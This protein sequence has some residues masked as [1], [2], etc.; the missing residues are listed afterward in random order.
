LIESKTGGSAPDTRD[1]DDTDMSDTLTDETTTEYDERTTI[2]DC[3]DRGEI[4]EVHND[5]DQDVYEIE[6]DDGE[7]DEL[8]ATEL[9]L[10]LAD[11]TIEVV[12]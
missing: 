3:G 1:H 10:G 8:T 11:G 6:Y 12:A 2:I 9:Q 5:Y 7:T 4:V